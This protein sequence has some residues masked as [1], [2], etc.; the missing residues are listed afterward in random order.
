MK[1]QL[2]RYVCNL[3]I[4]YRDMK[5]IVV[6]L[7]F[8]Y[9]GS[10]YAQT[11]NC[12]SNFQWL[13]SYIENNYPGFK[14]KVNI[15]T[16]SE[17]N[18]NLSKYEPL[19]KQAIKP[20]YCEYYILKWLDFFKDGHLQIKSDQGNNLPPEAENDTAIVRRLNN[21]AETMFFDSSVFVN[22]LIIN[23][24]K[25]VEGIYRSFDSTYTIA[26]VKNKNAFRDY[27]GIILNSKTK[28]W[29]KGEIKIELK[30]L[31]DTTYSML[32]YMRNHSVRIAIGP[33]P[34]KLNRAHKLYEGWEK[35]IPPV[36]TEPEISKNISSEDNKPNTVFKNLD[37][38]ISYLRIHSFDVSYA[39]AIDSI[40]KANMT[41]I[42][43]HKFMILDLRSNGGGSDYSYSP[44]VPILYTNPVLD[45][46]TDVY[47]TPD[48]TKAVERLLKD[49]PNLPGDVKKEIDTVIARMKAHPNQFTTSNSD[50]TITEDSVLRY[51][52]KVAILINQNCGSTTEE[53]LLYAKE[54]KKVVL[55]GENSAGVLDYSNIRP[56]DFPSMPATLYYPVTLSRRV[57]LHKGI[58][59][60][61]IP[62][63]VRLNPDSD[64]V[65]EAENYLLKK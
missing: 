57:A 40:I 52:E 13:K 22:G 7:F 50:D 54:C 42:K 60:I 11:C 25:D 4:L 61:G 23:N 53:F 8:I 24:E 3:L 30:Q 2:I 56:V 28:F 14:A 6:L 17:Y 21:M 31:S 62:P 29:H 1:S 47:S 51:P 44:L 12:D 15:Q 16:Q 58:D 43:N 46:G 59:G 37:G 55:M 35:I 49:N 32:M 64:W 34:F 63:N 65:K 26:I 45:I 19:I 33:L 18:A 41:Q 20:A 39:R 27:A 38:D 10:V 9:Y 36:K 5:R 48:N